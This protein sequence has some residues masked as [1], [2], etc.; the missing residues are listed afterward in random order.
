MNI[1]L[2]TLGELLTYRDTI[3]KR[4]AISILKRLQD[5]EEKTGD[6]LCNCGRYA[7]FHLLQDNCK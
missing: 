4:N 2:K 7:G 6:E 3:I 1:T 5:L